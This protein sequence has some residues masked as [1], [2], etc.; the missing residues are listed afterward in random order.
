MIWLLIINWPVEQQNSVISTVEV[1][2][3]AQ[4]DVVVESGS[5]NSGLPEKSPEI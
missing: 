3:N 2:L 4:V 5:V 1:L